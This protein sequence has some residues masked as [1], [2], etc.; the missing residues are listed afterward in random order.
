MQKVQKGTLEL[1]GG[2]TLPLELGGGDTLPRIIVRRT[3]RA[4][5]Y[6][7]NIQHTVKL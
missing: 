7:H 3:N 4:Q 5:N 2:D 6:N 1:G